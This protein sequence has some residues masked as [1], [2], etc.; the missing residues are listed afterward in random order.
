M[1]LGNLFVDLYQ[2]KSIIKLDGFDKKFLN[3]MCVVNNKLVGLPTGLNASTYIINKDFL[4]RYKVNLDTEWNWENLLDI[5]TRIHNQ[6]KNA[7]LMDAVP[8]QVWEMV[9]SYVVN[10]SGKPFILNDYT[11]GFN[12][13]M[14][15]DAFIYCRKLYD[16]GVLL[17]FEDSYLF[18]GT[19]HTNIKWINGNIGMCVGW[20]SAYTEYLSKKI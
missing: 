6:N 18:E 10:Q 17:Q 11:I 14:I 8:D 20:A 4:K 12:K 1:N 19:S 7:Y 2:Y 9:K 16:A 5:G 3:D 15:T 13:N